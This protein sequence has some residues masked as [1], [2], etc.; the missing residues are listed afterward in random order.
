MSLLLQGG[1]SPGKF[2]FPAI[3]GGVKN[4]LWE[5]D[6]VLEGH[7]MGISPLPPPLPHYVPYP[8]YVPEDGDEVP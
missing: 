5:G 1:G 6:C 7:P 3:G 2:S 4:C 8:S